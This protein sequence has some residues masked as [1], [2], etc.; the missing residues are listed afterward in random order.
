MRGKLQFF[1]KKLPHPNIFPGHAK[2]KHSKDANKA[3]KSRLERTEGRNSPS[4][5]G[6][7]NTR[8]TVLPSGWVHQEQSK[9]KVPR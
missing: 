5:K 3:A 1:R 6:C 7:F 2:S 8:R 9:G 4:K